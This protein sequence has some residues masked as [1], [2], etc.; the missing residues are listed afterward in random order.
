MEN[1]DNEETETTETIKT[2][3][4]LKLESNVS[5]TV[6]IVSWLLMMLL[7]MTSIFIKDD[8]TSDIISAVSGFI[9]YALSGWVA[10]YAIADFLKK[11]RMNATIKN[12]IEIPEEGALRDMVDFVEG[13]EV[14]GDT[15]NTPNTPEDTKS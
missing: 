11:R 12:A 10:G 5:N 15:F 2:E 6:I 13:N 1:T 14:N 7:L 9:A 4:K 3:Y 8:F